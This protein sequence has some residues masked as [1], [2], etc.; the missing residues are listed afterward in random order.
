MTKKDK[1]KKKDKPEKEIQPREPGDLQSEVTRASRSMRTFLTNSLSHSGIYAGQD[2][3]ILALA[4]EDGLSAGAIADRLGVK[5][6]TMT[7]TLARME[8]QGFIQ[9]Q[10][11]AADGRQLRAVLTEEGRK[12]VHAIQLAAK[13]TENMALSALSDKEIRQFLKV[14]RKINRNLGQVE[15][16]AEISGE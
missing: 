6:P 5:P 13:A 14:L 12:H 10:N 3:V 2:G 15:P 9:R 1:S 7:R 16:E 8:A 4:E 11:D